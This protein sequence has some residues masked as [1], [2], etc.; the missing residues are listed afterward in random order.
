MFLIHPR[1]FFR[2]LPGRV[3]TMLFRFQCR[4][5][6]VHLENGDNTH[7]RHCRVRSLSTGA[8]SIGANCTLR[9]AFFHFYENGG[10][11]ELM[12]WVYINAFPRARVSFSVKNQ[13]RILIGEGCLFSNSIDVSTTD[14]HRV[15]DDSGNV[16]NPEKDV[17]IG[18]HVWIG[19]KVTVC[20]GVSIPNDS[21]IGVGSVVTRSFDET[22]VVIAGNPAEIKKRGVNWKR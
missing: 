20:K 11:V 19:R 13:S 5:H 22:N 1:R 18:E 17:C 9:G 21:I 7:I 8:I 2:K 4:I 3:E 6:H 10:R 12:D 14:W 15:F 16:L